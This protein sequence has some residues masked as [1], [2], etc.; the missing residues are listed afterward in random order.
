MFARDI[1]RLGTA[2]VGPNSSMWDL[3][4]GMSHGVAGGPNGRRSDIRIVAGP[5]VAKMDA[6][7]PIGCPRAR[8]GEPV[9]KW[10]P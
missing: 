6:R 10:D 9:P 2:M 4:F 7:V 5:P 3:Q 8:R 1:L